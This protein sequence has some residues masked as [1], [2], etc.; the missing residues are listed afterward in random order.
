[1]YKLLLLILTFNISIAN[2][3]EIVAKE[4][5]IG[6]ASFKYLLFNVYDAE[7]Y[8]EGEFSFDKPFALKLTY[9]RNLKGYDIAKRSIKEMKKLGLEDKDKIYSWGEK[10]KYSFPNVK[11]NTVLTGYYYPN[12]KSKFTKDNKEIAT[13]DDSD[14]GK[15]FFGIW[16]DKKTSRPDFRKKLLGN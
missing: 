14:F 16:L 4:N 13:I 7:L 10:M 5:L 6:S 12:D 8:S 3:E 11:E 1:M 2:S 15:W 9:K